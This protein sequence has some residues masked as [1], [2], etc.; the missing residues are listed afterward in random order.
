MLVSFLSFD[1]NMHLVHGSEAIDLRPVRHIS[2]WNFFSLWMK[3]LCARADN[4]T[5]ITI[6]IEFDKNHNWKSFKFSAI[7]SLSSDTQWLKFRFYWFLSLFNRTWGGTANKVETLKYEERLRI[8]IMTVPQ[9]F[10]YVIILVLIHRTTTAPTPT[11]S[12]GK[13][14]A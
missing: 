4:L 13:I 8:C 14:I 5:H 11:G 7:W 3:L 12:D 9:S 6:S 10:R 2:K 1:E